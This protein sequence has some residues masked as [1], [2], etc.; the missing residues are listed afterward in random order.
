MRLS[1]FLLLSALIVTS[2]IFWLFPASIKAVGFVTLLWSF[3]MLS[4][5]G[6][7]IGILEKNS[8]HFSGI[9]YLPSR[10]LGAMSHQK[11]KTHKAHLLNI[12]RAPVALY[13]S[14]GLAYIA[15]GLY[16]TLNS[17]IPETLQG[18]LSNTQILLDEDTMSVRAI[19]DPYAHTYIAHICMLI[20]TGFIFIIG[21]LKTAPSENNKALLTALA[22]LFITHW[23]AALISSLPIENP[24]A[25]L[26]TFQDIHTGWHTA[27]LLASLQTNI[28]TSYSLLTQRIIEAGW[29][30]TFI[31]YTGALLLISSFLRRISRKSTEAHNRFYAIGALTT[32]SMLLIADIAFSA[33]SAALPALWLSGWA[34][35]ACLWQTTTPIKQKRSNTN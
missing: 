12:F 5:L 1:S 20:T 28:S 16:I 6:N 27:E 32:L 26:S 17:N 11:H 30:G 15:W 35:I 34:L 14:C 8:A 33:Q 3:L 22:G 23:T 19:I 4:S 18:I 9:S 21:I 24:I 13:L 31:L 25:S 2:I 29:V 10:I 7:L